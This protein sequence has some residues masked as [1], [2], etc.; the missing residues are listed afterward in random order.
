MKREFFFINMYLLKTTS[1]CF[2]IK[3]I[4]FI[5]KM[6]LFIEHRSHHHK[7]VSLTNEV[8]PLCQ[9]KGK[10]K[11]HIMQKYQWMIGP[12][13]PLPKYG[14]LECDAC[15]KTIPNNKWNDTLDAI[16]K[17]EKTTVKTPTKM[18]R[19]MWVLPLIFVAFI[20]ALKIIF[21]SSGLST[22]D[23]EKHNKDTRIELQSVQKETV[24]FVTNTNNIKT[25]EDMK[26][27]YR[28]VKIDK[29]VGDTAF[30]KTYLQKWGDYNM[31]YELKKASLDESKYSQEVLPMS[32][33]DIKK[34][35]IL[36][37]LDGKKYDPSSLYG[38]INGVIK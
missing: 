12:M 31:V 30:I 20:G 34:N 19:G 24:L 32:L 25:N 10:L 11:L 6:V 38:T 27:M 1:C 4:N 35:Q 14:V 37:K 29:I 36:T 23:Y 28:V 26:S 22:S 8:C 3:M 21:P 5:K 2:S 9:E 13:T 18:W 15:N 7:T 33:S 17:K 16:Y